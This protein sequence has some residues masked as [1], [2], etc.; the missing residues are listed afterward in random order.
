[1]N[2]LSQQQ[3][4]HTRQLLQKK[5]RVERQQFLVEGFHCVEE[6]LQSDWNVDMLIGT[7]NSYANNSAKHIHLL[8]KQKK[9]PLV[10][11]STQEIEKLS[12]TQTTQ[13]IFA[14][15]DKKKNWQLAE[16]VHAPHTLIVAFDAVSDPGNLGAMLRTCDWFGVDVV[17]LGKNC[18]EL[19]NPKVLRASMG[20]VFHLPIVEERNLAVELQE[21]Q[22]QHFSIFSTVANGN[23]SFYEIPPTLRNAKSVLVFGN[24]AHGISSELEQ[25]SDGVFSIPKFGKA[26][27]LNVASA[28]SAVLAIW[29]MK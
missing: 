14:V 21:F 23:R 10:E 1:M 6:A 29:K 25:R 16:Y 17:L 8:S 3:L 26:E 24:E 9:I 18:V 4:K 13:G 28:L 15:V 5:F 7:E 11:I 27:S 20:A 19:F 12:D 22:L 2:S